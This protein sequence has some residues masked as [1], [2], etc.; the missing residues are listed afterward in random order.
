VSES[1]EIPAAAVEAAEKAWTKAYWTEATPGKSDWM[2]A[3]LVAARP[4]LMPTREALWEAIV[5]VRD[6]A[7]RVPD[8]ADSEDI[9]DAVLALLNGEIKKGEDR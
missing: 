1:V 4:Y 5:A 8:D 7:P 9:V 2:R 6:A 3:A